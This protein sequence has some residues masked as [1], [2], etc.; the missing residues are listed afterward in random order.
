MSPSLLS[1]LPS[2]FRKLPSQ[3]AS[4]SSIEAENEPNLPWEELGSASEHLLPQLR[5]MYWDGVKR[6]LTHILLTLREW[7][8]PKY[9]SILLEDEEDDFIHGYDTFLDQVSYDS[10]IFA[11]RYGTSALPFAMCAVTDVA[12]YPSLGDWHRDGVLDSG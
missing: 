10:R 1:S 12:H 8:L 5:K 7:Q 3:S 2:A 11:Q 4:Q 9:S 6:E